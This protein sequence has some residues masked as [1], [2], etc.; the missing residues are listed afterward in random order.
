LR[1][2]NPGVRLN[3]LSS[4]ASHHN[5]PEVRAALVQALQKDANPGVRVQAID[6]LTDEPDAELTGVLQQL[7]RDEPNSYV[8]MRSEQALQAMNA[9]V[10]L[11]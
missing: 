2:E 9:S 1:D 11:Y 10:E 7:V 8:R 6:L 5:D 3:A 4:L